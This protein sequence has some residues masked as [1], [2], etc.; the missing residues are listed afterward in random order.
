[1]LELI[2]TMAQKK[3]H[4]PAQNEKKKNKNLTGGN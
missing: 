4:K 3:V 1:V 2:K